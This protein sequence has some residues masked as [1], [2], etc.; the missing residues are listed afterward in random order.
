MTPKN[1]TIQIPV[2]S[3]DGASPDSSEETSSKTDNDSDSGGGG[4][5][6]FIAVIGSVGNAMPL[7]PGLL[8]LGGALLAGRR[9]Q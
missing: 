6:C 9:R 5:G 3:D 7:W 4:G 1:I 8:C 2:E